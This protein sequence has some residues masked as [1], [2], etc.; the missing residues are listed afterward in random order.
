MNINTVIINNKCIYKEGF[1]RFL[2][3]KNPP[4]NAGDMSSLSGSRRSSGEEM[5]ILCSIFA[6]EIHGQRSLGG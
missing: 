1:P 5:A 2:S 6:W 3:S 4:A